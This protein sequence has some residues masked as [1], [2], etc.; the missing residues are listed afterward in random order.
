MIG[1]FPSADELADR[2]IESILS[3]LLRTINAVTASGGVRAKTT[4]AHEISFLYHKREGF[5]R[6]GYKV[7][8]DYPNN[9]DYD[10]IDEYD[11]TAAFLDWEDAVH[12]R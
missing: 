1:N 3:D 2:S 11:I 9:L 7:L 6:L 12:I 4:T 10:E 8:F 5:E